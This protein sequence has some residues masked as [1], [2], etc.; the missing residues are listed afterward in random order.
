[1]RKF[2]AILFS[3]SLIAS[4]LGGCKAKE[5]SENGRVYYLNF[6]PEQ[7]EAWQNVAK[8]YTE[9]T[10]I[11]VEVVTASQGSYEETLTAEID[12]EKAPTL[13]QLSGQTALDAWQN[14]CLD[15]SDT[16][17]YRQLSDDDFALKRDGKV[18]GIGYVYEGYG[19]IVN[20]KLLGQAGYEMA[21]ITSFDT[22]K[23]V[24]EDIHSR[25]KELGFDA[26]TSSTLD[27]ASSW[28]FSGH[29]ANIP[30]F[31]EFDEGEITSQPA[32]I[33]GKYLDSFK[34]LWDLYTQ[35]ATIEPAKITTSMDAAKEFASGKAVFYQNGTWAY[36]D[37]KSV[38]DENLGLLPIYAGIDDQSQG[39]SCGT[40]NYW[41]VNAKASEIDRKATLDF[42]AWMVT[43]EIGTTAL[44]EQMGF[45][46]PFKKAKEVDNVLANQMNAY[47]E[48]G[49]YT[50]IAWSFQMT[51]NVSAWRDELVSA[52]AAYTTGK[53]S[54][55]A[56]KT[57]FVDG[58]ARQYQAAHS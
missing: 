42:L 36:E 13:F 15:L 18:Y 14:Y 49:D 43:S 52:L 24:A 21:D 34:K 53:G 47:I 30:L 22:L 16:E 11:P 5:T 37:V 44:A 2:L 26:F 32:S 17:V 28:R 54:W 12:K 23:S 1:M 33:Q 38:G 27:S 57:A 8:K 50:N 3:L 20:Q 40:E 58:W 25:A 31:Y 19:L 29:L 48:K 35:N 51:P 4:L 10:G 39:V 9:E 41:A 56:V 55:D 46:A 7:D 6:K 45:V